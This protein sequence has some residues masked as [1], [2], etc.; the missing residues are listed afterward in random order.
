[1]IP[2]IVEAVES[3]LTKWDELDGKEVDL[4]KEFS[5]LTSQ[6]IS[7]SA[8]GSSYS[9]GKSIF[10]KIDQLAAFAAKYSQKI[11]LPFIR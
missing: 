10:N 4:F 1:M 6:V 5:F 9:E 8:F 2:G 7:R 11:Q 3:I